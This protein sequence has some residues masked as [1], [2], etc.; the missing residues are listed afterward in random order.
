MDLT[1]TKKGLL[2]KVISGDN[3]D[4]PAFINKV[5]GFCLGMR[6]THWETTNYELHKAV[7]MT[8]AS[9]EDALDAFVEAAIGLNGGNRPTLTGT[10]T[11]SEDV[12]GF[13]SFLRTIGTRDTSLLNI[14]DEMLQ[15]SY[16]F[17]YLKGLK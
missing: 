10:V 5:Q 12:D 14:R 16:K 2:T 6:L 11:R 9:L 8:Q 4:L 17:K 15:A 1:G 3:F 7:E 13:I